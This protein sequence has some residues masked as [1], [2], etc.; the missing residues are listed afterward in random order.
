MAGAC[1]Q[2]RGIRWDSPGKAG[3]LFQEKGTRPSQE[4]VG[5]AG[6]TGRQGDSQSG[7][8]SVGREERDRRSAGWEK[9]GVPSPGA[10]CFPVG[11]SDRC[12][13]G[14]EPGEAVAGREC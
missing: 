13:C 5:R 10:R 14:C 3:R 6:P 12:P 11:G 4:G 7:Q 2:P 9:P 1:T 8:R